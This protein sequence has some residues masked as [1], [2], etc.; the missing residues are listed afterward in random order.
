M[1]APMPPKAP[2]QPPPPR[3]RASGARYSWARTS[4][5]RSSSVDTGR[6]ACPRFR[7]IISDWDSTMGWAPARST[8]SRTRRLPTVQAWTSGRRPA[9][10]GA[11]PGRTGGTP[12]GSRRDPDRCGP[13]TGRAAGL[14]SVPPWTTGAATATSGKRSTTAFNTEGRIGEE[15][16]MR[17]RSQPS[18]PRRA[19]SVS[20]AGQRDPAL[21]LDVPTGPGQLRIGEQLVEGGDVGQAPGRFAPGEARQTG[22]SDRRWRGA[23]A[24]RRRSGWRRPGTTGSR[25]GRPARRRF[26][27]PS[28]GRGR[29]SR[30]G[31]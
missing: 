19:S 7:R 18:S 21:D 30:C 8:R 17:D 15:T 3:A 22:G 24:G 12:A 26:G 14:R 6:G 9:R 31:S 11:G 13:G 1:T 28:G 5:A 29:R 23:T 2:R 27:F 20:R 4:R 25:P 10:S 16:R